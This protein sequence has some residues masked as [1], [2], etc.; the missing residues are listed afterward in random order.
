MAEENI[1]IS[2][3]L[4]SRSDVN[5]VI[6]LTFSE[7][8]E[9]DNRS[10][11]VKIKNLFQ[12][13]NSLFYDIP[14]TGTLSHS[15]LFVQSRDYINDFY[16]PKDD[17]IE[18]L[19]E[20]IETLEDDLLEATNDVNP[21][22]PIYNDGTFVKVDGNATVY[23]MYKGKACAVTGGAYN[24]LAKK[25]FPYLFSDDFDGDKFEIVI[26]IDNTSGLPSR[27]PTIKG[28]TDINNIDNLIRPYLS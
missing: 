13:Y 2:K 27:G 1:K 11:D 25:Y 7:L 28:S 4:Y 21:E 17:Q 9:K 14:K 10:T 12:E 16:D 20:R 19:L 3:K 15:T 8:F 5:N 22:H 26:E 24:I 6:D 18:A 23:F